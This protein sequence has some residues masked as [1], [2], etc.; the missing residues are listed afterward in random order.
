MVSEENIKLYNKFLDDALIW[1]AICGAL[2]GTLAIGVFNVV[3]T[4]EKYLTSSIFLV[5]LCAFTVYFSLKHNKEEEYEK[6]TSHAFW[7]HALFIA[8]P[9]ALFMLLTLIWQTE[10]S[11]QN[12]AEWFMIILGI[13]FV[14]SFITT[15]LKIVALDKHVKSM[16]SFEKENMVSSSESDG[17]VHA[18]DDTEKNEQGDV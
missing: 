10:I 1:G 15:A 13:G 16:L 14:I 2:I 5:I 8:T 6:K 18:Q 17:Q 3:G 7:L 4:P 12:Y 9:A 11:H